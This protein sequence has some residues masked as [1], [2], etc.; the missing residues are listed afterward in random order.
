[1][2]KSM[3]SNR[4]SR[5]LYATPTQSSAM[6]TTGHMSSVD[7]PPLQLH[8][9]TVH[10]QSVSPPPHA[11]SHTSRLRSGSATSTS[12]PTVV[13]KSVHSN[14]SA[15]TARGASSSLRRDQLSAVALGLGDPLLL[16]RASPAAGSRPRAGSSQR[17]LWSVSA[18]PASTAPRPTKR[19]GAAASSSPSPSNVTTGAFTPSAGNHGPDP[20]RVVIT[21]HG[22]EALSFIRDPVEQC[23]VFSSSDASVGASSSGQYYC[24]ASFMTHKERVDLGPKVA[25][26]VARQVTFQGNH[27]VV[28]AFGASGSGKTESV[29]GVG[30]AAQCYVSLLMEELNRT[31]L[32]KLWSVQIAVLNVVDG[33]AFDALP[34]TFQPRRHAAHDP[35]DALMAM[36]EGNA[37]DDFFHRKTSANVLDALRGGGSSD[38]GTTAAHARSSSQLE[39]RELFQK[40]SVTLRDSDDVELFFESIAQRARARHN[41]TWQEVVHVC[42]VPTLGVQQTFG[43]LMRSVGSVCFVELGAGMSSDD[44]LKL[45]ARA[46]NTQRHTVTT[47][48]NV[49]NALTRAALHQRP[50]SSAGNSTGASAPSGPLTGSTPSYAVHVPYGDCTLTTLLEPFLQEANITLIA[51]VHEDPEE[52]TASLSTL[53]A[54]DQILRYRYPNGKAP[55]DYKSLARSQCLRAER[56]ERELETTKKQWEDERQQLESDRWMLRKAYDDLLQQCDDIGAATALVKDSTSPTSSVGAGGGSFPSAD[57]LSA[58]E[59]RYRELQQS[60]MTLKSTHSQ[61][62]RE[63]CVLEEHITAVTEELNVLRDA[64]ERLQHDREVLL[65][66]YRQHEHRTH[67]VS[68]A[69][70]K[71]DFADSP[72]MEAGKLLSELLGFLTS[73]EVISFPP[74]ASGMASS[75]VNV[76]SGLQAAHSK[77]VSSPSVNGNSAL[78]L[79]KAAVAILQLTHQLAERER[80]C[81]ANG[82]EMQHVS[83]D[84]VVSS[85]NRKA[86]LYKSNLSSSQRPHDPTTASSSS[87]PPA[88]LLKW[89]TWRALLGRLHTL[90]TSVVDH[91]NLCTA[92]YMLQADGIGSSGEYSIVHVNGTA[93]RPRNHGGIGLFQLASASSPSVFSEFWTTDHSSS[94]AF[95]A[96]ATAATVAVTPTTTSPQGTVKSLP[97]YRPLHPVSAPVPHAAHAAAL[98]P[99]STSSV[100]GLPPSVAQQIFQQSSKPPVRQS[101]VPRLNSAVVNNMPAAARNDVF[102]SALRDLAHSGVMPPST[103]AMYDESSTDSPRVGGDRGGGGVRAFD[104]FVAFGDDS[105]SPGDSSPNGFSFGEE[106][107]ESSA[108]ERLLRQ[109]TSSL[110]DMPSPSQRQRK[111]SHSNIHSFIDR[112]GGP[113][114]NPA[115]SA[116]SPLRAAKPLVLD[117]YY[118]Q[119]LGHDAAPALIV[120]EPS[121]SSVRSAPPSTPSATPGL[122]DLGELAS[123]EHSEDDA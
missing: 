6:K 75:S 109:Q 123:Y 106:A 41:V 101:T 95:V 87:N 114:T 43:G 71:D 83:K 24:D 96:Q 72:L 90:G 16:R 111:Q 44:E 84:S 112:A 25:D 102:R 62:Q 104:Q 74:G 61:V 28:F 53:H 50:T 11:S 54:V 82:G 1:M 38:A 78:L 4:R 33:Q 35:Q 12:A 58:A 65:E 19:D 26:Q 52:R 88:Y 92:A 70:K 98:S 117:P 73:A 48:L 3:S 67:T 118:H 121:L 22:Q 99:S 23:V 37:E 59:D 80:I 49:L 21:S 119:Y 85:P 30:G 107:P 15:S 116:A 110:D 31:F 81:C 77:P 113:T 45:N 108:L 100:I 29:F 20:V 10:R 9:P 2:F 32:S 17:P 5:Q 27:S 56:A 47:V 76:T 18:R 34:R 7:D 36:L 122:L 55:V 40:L 64:H 79:T 105:S 97:I 57:A 63:K 94:T 89:Q 115:T 120:T 91:G 14:P 103:P 42:V 51:H 13:A 69:G 93:P 66:R 86:S 39:P 8:E 68:G 60:H 46:A